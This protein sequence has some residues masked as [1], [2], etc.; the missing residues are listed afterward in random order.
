MLIEWKDKYRTGVPEVDHEHQ[1][2]VAIINSLHEG[3]K[4][5]GDV[6]GFF[7]DLLAAISAHFALEE[8]AMRRPRIRI[9]ARTRTTTSVC[10]TNCATSWIRTRPPSARSNRKRSAPRS[11][12]GS[13]CISRRSTPGCT[14]SWDRR[15]ARLVAKPDGRRARSACI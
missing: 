9:S 3:S 12:A 5:D 8:R 2:L 6:E 4:V 14:T 7:G 13:P 10:S 1:E 11:I 15:T